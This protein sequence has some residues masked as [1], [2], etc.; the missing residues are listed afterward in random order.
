MRRRQFLK[1][2]A[3]TGTGTLLL[4]KGT[5]FGQ[6]AP[7]NK[8]NIALI[9]VW[10]RALAHYNTLSTQNVVALCDIDDNHLASAVKKWPD[11]KTYADWRKCLDQKGLDAVVS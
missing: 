9:G 2:L 10:G 7:G 1:S 8:L 3:L 5:L 6:N 4:R 11:A